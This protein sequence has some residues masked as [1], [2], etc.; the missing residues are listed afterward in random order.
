MTEDRQD[1]KPMA[2]DAA[3][4]DARVAAVLPDRVR[5]WQDD[6][7]VLH[8][9]VDGRTFHDVSPRRLFPLSGKADWVSFTGSD[10][11][12]VLLLAHPHKLDR[13]SRACL[14][15]ALGRMYYTPRILRVDAITEAMGVSQWKVM[16]DRGYAVFEI[17]ERNRDIRKFPA[18]RYVISDVDGNRFEIENVNELDVRSR[19]IVDSET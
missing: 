17:A 11:C 3:G 2:A 9:S 6:Y 7:H 4:D 12:E 8:V 5:V 10:G 14:D 16:T 18:G 19:S 15:R 13:E 1:S